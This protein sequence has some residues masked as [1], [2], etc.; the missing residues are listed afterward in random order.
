MPS[1]Q[2][3]YGFYRTMFRDKTTTFVVAAGDSATKEDVI[4]PR[5]ARHTIY[6]QRITLSVITDAAQSLTFQDDASSAV[7]IAKSAASP[8]LGVEIVC[9]FGPIG[10]ALTEGKNLDI[11]ISG[12]GLA[13]KGV[14]EGY[15][16]LT[17]V[18]TAANA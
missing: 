12:A 9:D 2:A 17:A 14:I 8:G 5:N 16:K 13:C 18:A 15:E 11:V 3:D 6:V 1:I 7:I 10:Y 4:T